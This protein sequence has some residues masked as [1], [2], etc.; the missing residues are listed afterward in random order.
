MD[1]V[2]PVISIVPW[3]SFLNKEIVSLVCHTF[4]ETVTKETSQDVARLIQLPAQK[5][6]VGPLSKVVSVV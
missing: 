2:F 4:I 5:K 1:A 6:K 3:S